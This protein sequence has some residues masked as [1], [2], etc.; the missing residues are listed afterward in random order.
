MQSCYI[1]K[2]EIAT[3]ALHFQPDAASLQNPVAS[4]VCRTRAE[5]PFL[6]YSSACSPLENLYRRELVL[7][8]FFQGFCGTYFGIASYVHCNI[9]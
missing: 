2:H 6:L 9:K 1:D 4:H 8:P 5:I 3:Y 7:Q